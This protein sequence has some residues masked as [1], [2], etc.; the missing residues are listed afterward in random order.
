KLHTVLVR[1]KPPY[2]KLHT[3]LVRPRTPNVKLQVVSVRPRT[4]H[5]KPQTALAQPRTP[6]INLHNRFFRFG[7]FLIKR[8]VHLALNCPLYNCFIISVATIE[9]ADY[10]K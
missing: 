3:V 7:F 6:H 5:V 9:E 8:S 10:S 2:V 1:P 4:P